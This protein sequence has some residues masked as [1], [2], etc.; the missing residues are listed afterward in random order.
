MTD[1]DHGAL[2]PRPLYEALDASGRPYWR[3]AQ[4]VHELPTSLD[5]RKALDEARGQVSGVLGLEASEPL[6][7]G[8]PIWVA[9]MPM[10]MAKKHPMWTLLATRGENLSL[11]HCPGYQR[12]GTS[13][14]ASG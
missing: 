7:F 6:P 9:F 14:P 3:E 10:A 8:A 2:T 4:V 11:D 12:P 13:V 1:Q 5:R